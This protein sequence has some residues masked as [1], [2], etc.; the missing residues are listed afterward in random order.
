[1]RAGRDE[2]HPF[3]F[4]FLLLWWFFFFFFVFLFFFFFLRMTELLRDQLQTG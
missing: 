3:F 1:M 4:C 2:S